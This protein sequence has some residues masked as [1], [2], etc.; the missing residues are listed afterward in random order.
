[1]YPYNLDKR[2]EESARIK[3]ILKT[4]SRFTEV[5]NAS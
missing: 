2:G 3:T 4:A 5:F 1:M